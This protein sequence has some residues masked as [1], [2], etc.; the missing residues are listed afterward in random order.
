[1][2]R[3]LVAKKVWHSSNLPSHLQQKSPSNVTIHIHPSFDVLSPVQ[4]NPFCATFSFNMKRHFVSLFAQQP[5][6]QKYM[7][8]KHSYGASEL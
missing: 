6:S 8:G 4:F 5:R 7:T 3:Y 1:M 2:D